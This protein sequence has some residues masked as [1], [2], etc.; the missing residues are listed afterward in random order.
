M[1]IDIELPWHVICDKCGNKIPVKL[2]I[3]FSDNIDIF[4]LIKT[5]LDFRKDKKDKKR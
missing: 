5:F 1:K 2:T 4:S 3:E